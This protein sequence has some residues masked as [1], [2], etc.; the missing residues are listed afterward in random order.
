MHLWWKE[1]ISKTII[2]TLKT[3]RSHPSIH[4]FMVQYDHGYR[5]PL[6]LTSGF[7]IPV[8]WTSHHRRHYICLERC[9]LLYFH[10]YDSCKIC[11]VSIRS[12]LDVESLCTKSFY[13]N[14]ADGSHN[15]HQ[16]YYCGTATAFWLGSWSCICTMVYWSGFY[17]N[18]LHWRSVFYHCSSQPSNRINEWNMATSNCTSG[19]SFSI[20]RIVGE[21]YRWE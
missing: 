21:S 10:Y 9:Y 5:Y 2:K 7:P 8:Q 4:S 19:R 13:W 18:M 3:N 11:H 14:H 20:R 15:H 17:V 6:S 1:K 16:L 12:Q